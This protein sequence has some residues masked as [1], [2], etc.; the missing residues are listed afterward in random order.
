MIVDQGAC[1]GDSNEL[2]ASVVANT[3][4]VEMEIGK[5]RGFEV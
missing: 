5:L 3:A 1:K 2:Q 4:F